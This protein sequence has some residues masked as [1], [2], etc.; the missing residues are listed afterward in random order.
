M[1]TSGKKSQRVKCN[2]YKVIVLILLVV[3][4]LIS[5]IVNLNNEVDQDKQA[6]VG[7]TKSED[8]TLSKITSSIIGNGVTYE[9]KDMHINEGSNLFDSSNDSWIALDNPDKNSTIIE[10]NEVFIVKQSNDNSKIYV[11]YKG[12]NNYGLVSIKYASDTS[13]YIIEDKEAIALTL[14][15]GEYNIKFYDIRGDKAI[16]KGDI[17][18]QGPDEQKNELYLGSSYYTDYSSTG[19]RFT[20]LVS[21]IY[22]DS[23][24][25]QDFVFNCYDYVSSLNYDEA[26]SE[27][28]LSGDMKLY[29]P[30]IDEIIELETG[31]CIDKSA[32][33]ASMLR[34]KG[35][36]TKVVI[37]YYNNMYHSWN[38]VLIDNNWY[39]LD[40]TLNI[41]YNSTLVKSYVV[42]KYN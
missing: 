8:N 6:N 16:Y 29:K 1:F 28:V 42:Q 25:I 10:S 11:K 4:L 18:I 27:M 40:A 15:N 24:S 32:L 14:G 26:K 5:Y 21:K 38:E 19:D 17:S 23:G 36:P 3:S 22:K 13:Q 34:A 39:L 20:Q 33:L 37:G 35:I 7:F 12:T 31:I 9:V 30:N 2:I 41:K